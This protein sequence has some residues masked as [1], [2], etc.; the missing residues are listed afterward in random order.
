MG[1]GEEGW[2]LLRTFIWSVEERV[3]VEEWEVG[4]L[5]LNTRLVLLTVT[6]RHRW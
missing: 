4:A 5:A 2:G 1:E 3:R 6:L